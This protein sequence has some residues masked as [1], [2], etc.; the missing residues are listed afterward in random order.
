MERR[1][2]PTDGAERRALGRLDACARAPIARDSQTI[3]PADVVATDRR[4]RRVTWTDRIGTRPAWLA[5]PAWALAWVLT[6][7]ALLAYARSFRDT[8]VD[9]AYITFQYARNLSDHLTWG[10]FPDRTTNTATS[11]LNVVLLALFD[12]LLPGS[13]I[14]AASWLTAAEWTA[15]L[16][17]LLRISRRL[18]G[19]PHFGLLAFAALLTNPLLLSGLGLEG[20]LYALLMLAAVALV[21]ERRWAALGVALALLTLARPDGL[22][23]GGLMLLALPAGLAARGRAVLALGLTALP[24]YLFAWVHLG[25]VVP[26]TLIIKL[27]QTAWGPTTFADG[28]D[29]YRVRYP[30]ATLASLWPLALAPFALV[31][32]WRAG[33]EARLAV[34]A[35]AAYAAAHYAAYA[36]LGVPPYHW[37]YSHQVVPIVVLGSL[38]AAY[39]LRGLTASRSRVDRWAAL[40]ATALPAAGLCYLASADGWPLRQ[41]PIHSNWGTPSQYR[42]VG[43]RLRDAVDP[44]ATVELQGEIGTLAYYSERRLVDD[45]ADLNRSNDA[46]A[47]LERRA[48]PLAERLLAANF[49]RRADEEPL[50]PPTHVLVFDPV[51]AGE[52]PP[53]SASDAAFSWDVSS[54]W[55]PWTRITLRAS[56]ALTLVV[57]ERAQ[58]GPPLPPARQPLSGSYEVITVAGGGPLAGRATGKW[59]EDRPVAVPVAPHSTVLVRV[60]H[61]D[62]AAGDLTT[63]V[64]A[65][66]RELVVIL[67]PRAPPPT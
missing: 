65:G 19:G 5:D 43:L 6:F 2:N 53:A 8:Y 62:Y 34:A 54:R 52:V 61:P 60:R 39:L 50:P 29:L 9:D 1:R 56:A 25:S 49:A 15:T 18:L 20:Y 64:G 57:K 14:A 66:H 27:E 7:A 21:L 32:A 16:A 26:D 10:F 47:D 24:W 63:S 31:P 40:A 45:F 38:G 17:V 3:A 35:L 42:A 33:R 4:S 48:D 58:D 12:R 11:P 22:L 51:D 41:A 59:R 44:T 67:T 13:I 46:I 37:Y 55:L 30:A 36:A 23:L 28:F